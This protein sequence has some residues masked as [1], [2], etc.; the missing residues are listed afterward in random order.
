MALAK[1]LI[2]N[3]QNI[4]ASMTAMPNIILLFTIICTAAFE[5]ILT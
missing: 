5:I 1:Y 2:D 4:F 3:C